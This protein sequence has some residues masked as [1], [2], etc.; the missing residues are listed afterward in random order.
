MKKF[1]IYE[2]TIDIDALKHSMQHDQAGAFISFEGWV[3]NHHKGRTVDG[4]AYQAY[5]ALA[6][7]EGE[8]IMMDALE[9][10]EILHVLCVHRTGELAIGDCAVWV[11][12]TAAHRDA[13]F[14]ACRFVIDEVK[15]RVPI[16]KKERYEDGSS[17]WLHPLS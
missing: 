14:A 1:Q 9:K 2:Q 16:W 13:A 12:V 10:F 11:G 17:D 5:S 8:K 6:E 3:R 4:L 7:T 15:L